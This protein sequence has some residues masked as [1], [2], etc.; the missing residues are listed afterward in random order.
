MFGRFRRFATYR[1]IS[2]LYIYVMALYSLQVDADLDAV[3]EED[4]DWF[5]LF[6]SK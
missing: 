5:T 6:C 4:V 2:L 1:L 3:A